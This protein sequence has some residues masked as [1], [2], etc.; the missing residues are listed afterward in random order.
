VPDGIRGS[1][2]CG[3]VRARGFVVAPGYGKAR[4]AMIRIGHMGDHSV[5]GLD[6]LLDVLTDVFQEALAAHG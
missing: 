4:D 5:A 2:V 1:D 6:A 3:A